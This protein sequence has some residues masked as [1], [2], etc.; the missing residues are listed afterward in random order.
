MPPSKSI[1]RILFFWLVS[2]LCLIAAACGAAAVPMIPTPLPTA[3]TTYTPSPSRTPGFDSTPTARPTSSGFS[4]TGGPSP[5]P[6]FGPT[7]TP[8]DLV[9]T[10][11][12]PPNPNA[13]RIEFFTSDVLAVAPGQSVTLFWSTRNVTGATIYRVDQDGVR[14]QL[15][16]VP[17]D[18]NLI[19]PTRRSDRGEVNFVLSISDGPVRIEKPLILPLSC[20]D[21]WFFEPPPQSTLRAATVSMPYSTMACSPRGSCSRTATTL[22]A[23]LNRKRI[24]SLR[25]GSSSRYASWVS[26]GEA[27]IWCV[28]VSVWAQR[29][30]SASTASHNP[31]RRLRRFVRQQRGLIGLGT[32]PRRRI[33]ADYHD[34]LIC[35]DYN[36]R[37]CGI[38]N[39]V[40]IQKQ[41]V[42]ESLNPEGKLREIFRC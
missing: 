27:T 22:P 9:E 21:A 17:S 31:R 41:A 6:L 42:C 39:I 3:T 18:G 8:V 12:R 16:N 13:P 32:R 15:W 19:V 2:L 25:R 24:S 37:R 10:A 14:S 38:V 4:A 36:L 5:T 35:H 1:L 33:V 11:T 20:P 28:T 29:R 23:T 40:V 30:T 26:S 34:A 7:R